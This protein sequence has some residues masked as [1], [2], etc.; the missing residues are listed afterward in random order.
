MLRIEIAIRS[1]QSVQWALGAPWAREENQERDT[2]KRPI[3]DTMLRRP[4]DLNHFLEHQMAF[5]AKHLA[6]PYRSEYSGA[7]GIFGHIHQR[8]FWWWYIS[9][10]VSTSSHQTLKLIL[11]LCYLSPCLQQSIAENPGHSRRGH[12]DL[13]FMQLL[14]SSILQFLIQDSLNTQFD[15]I[16]WVYQFSPTSRTEMPL[17]HEQ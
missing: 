3:E 6:L 8:I 5:I 7:F 10:G 16:L 11:L 1:H 13:S 15:K 14:H 12:G 17:A 9:P 2:C 4:F